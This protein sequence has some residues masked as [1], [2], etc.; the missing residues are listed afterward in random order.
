VE[1]EERRDG[2]IVILRP[3]GRIDNSSAVPLQARLFAAVERNAKGCILDLSAVP[4][5]ASF[6]MR[7][8]IATARLA[9]GRRLVVAAPSPV[10]SDVFKVAHLAQVV[11]IFDTVAA[12]EAA[13]AT[14]P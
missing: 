1:I 10:V 14:P 9:A 12:A 8:I 11:P 6:G 2:S 4:Y 7:A 5:I 3:V 13:L